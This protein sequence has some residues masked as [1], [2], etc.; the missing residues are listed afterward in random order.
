MRKITAVLMCVSLLILTSGCA[1][2]DA[3]SKGAIAG[4]G[5]GALLGGVISKDD[6]AKG[7]MIGAALGAIAGAEIGRYLD[8]KNKTAKETATAYSYKPE[9]GTV[10]NVETVAMEPALVKPGGTSK[11]VINYALLTSDSEKVISVTETR[12]IMSGGKTLKAIG[13]AVKQR[14]SGTY[15]TEQEVTFPSNLPEGLY[16]LKGSVEAQGKTS[17]KE[18]EFK[19]SKIETDSGCLYAINRVVP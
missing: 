7:A 8:K 6:P 18:T 11:L 17:I 10:V 16:T 19:V 4:A 13:P 3:K 2:M 1:T 15:I 12:E 9:K 5:I 14:D